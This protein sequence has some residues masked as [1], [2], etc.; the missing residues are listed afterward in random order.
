MENESEFLMGLEGMDGLLGMIRVLN[1]MTGWDILS[2]K[3]FTI[4]KML[5]LLLEYVIS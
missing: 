3:S 4:S 5:S 1:V 2:P